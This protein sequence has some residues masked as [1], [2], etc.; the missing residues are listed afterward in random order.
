MGTTVN[1]VVYRHVTLQLIRA[2]EPRNS[3]LI[4]FFS[5]YTAFIRVLSDVFVFSFVQRFEAPKPAH[6]RQRRTET[7]WL[8]ARSRQIRPHQDL[9]ERGGNPVVSAARCAP[10][11]HGIQ[12]VNRHVVSLLTCPECHQSIFCITRFRKKTEQSRQPSAL[13][14]DL[15]LSRQRLCE[16]VQLI[17]RFAAHCRQLLHLRAV[18]SLRRVAKSK[19]YEHFY[20]WSRSDA[21]FWM[22]TIHN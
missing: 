19:S 4:T 11:L 14:C 18:G 20:P 6:Q 5:R 13:I 16:K 2:F 17:A 21:C 8:R 10:R 3:T 9:L 12:L 15:N 22:Q 1:S 7:R